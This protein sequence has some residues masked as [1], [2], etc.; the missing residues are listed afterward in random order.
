MFHKRWKQVHLRRQTSAVPASNYLQRGIYGPACYVLSATADI[1]HDKIFETAVVK[2]QRGDPLLRD[3]AAAL[4][5]FKIHQD[6][7]SAMSDSSNLSFV[8]RIL[9]TQEDA[10]K[11]RKVT[12]QYESTAHISPTSNICERL[13]SRAKLVMRPHRR[14]MDPSTLEAIL[15][16][17]T[18]RDLW[19]EVCIQKI[20]I[21]DSSERAARRM[22]RNE[23]SDGNIFDI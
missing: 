3:E 11:R 21:K 1:V 19:D 17:R 15:L 7:A 5:I 22:Q 13:F 10:H 23:S 14:H 9:H 2:L 16:L 20:M 4:Q 8:E 12:G 18:N 6:S